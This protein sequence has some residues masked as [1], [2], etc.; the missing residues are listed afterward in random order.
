LKYDQRKEFAKKLID[1]IVLEYGNKQKNFHNSKKQLKFIVRWY[2]IL[3]LEENF[4]ELY[5]SIK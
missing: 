3:I 2:A 1:G 4:E 5:Q